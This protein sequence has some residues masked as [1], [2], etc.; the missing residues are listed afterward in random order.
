MLKILG[1]IL[2]E[3]KMSF[4]LTVVLIF[5]FCLTDLVS[6]QAPPQN[7]LTQ[8]SMED[9]MNVQ[10]YSASKK[11]ERFFNT[12]AAITVITPE[13][14]QR[15]GAT[16][17]PELLRMV[18]GLNVQQV[19]SH[20]WDI[21]ARGFNGS[22][23]SNKLL[24]LID[25]RAVYTPLYGGVFW[26]VQ[27]VVLEDIERIEVIRGPGGTLWGANAVD[28]VINIITKKARDTQGGLI[29]AGSG[30]EN[31]VQT[32]LRYGL[33]AGHKDDGSDWFYR[34]YAKYLD[35]ADGFSDTG[36][37]NDRWQMARTG[38]RA[39]NSKLTFQGDFYQ[40]FLGQQVTETNFNEP[41]SEVVDR[42]A[43]VQGGN[44]MAKYEDEDFSLQSYWDITNRNLQAFEET[45]NAFDLDFTKHFQ[46]TDR[47]EITWG[48]GYRLNLED[49]RNTSSVSITSPD[50]ADQVFNTFLQ[51]EIK[52]NDKLKLTVGS[53]LEHNIYTH[54]EVEPNVRLSYDLTDHSFLWAA[55]SRAVRTPS[56]LEEDGE[57]T[58][59]AGPTVPV[60][61]MLEGNGNLASEKMRSYELGY[62][63][64]PRENI[65]VD[66]SLYVDHYD[67]LIT[68]TTGNI[69]MENGYAVAIYPAVN[70]LQGDVE[71]FELSS[72]IKLEEWWNLKAWYAFSKSGLSAYPGIADI[73]VRNFLENS[74][75]RQNAYMRSSFD[76]P[77]AFELDCTLHYTDS[78]DHEQVPSNTELDINLTKTIRQWQISLVGQNLLRSHHYESLAGQGVTQVARSGYIKATY[79]F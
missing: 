49:D 52:I 10:V 21:S 2:G 53:K 64:E 60:F 66:L 38:F 9:L 19:N 39:E 18:P 41:F 79:K 62:R 59:A 74:F 14:I 78:F 32:T 54:F 68:Y 58:G 11:A 5:V 48:A 26:D 31:K 16:S 37:A 29:S 30:N 3:I 43:T 55:A 40:G 73:G 72:D 23:F 34:A 57:I 69:I 75:P 50:Q 8:L 22:I 44:F 76:L 36:T 70:G 7:D 56:R 51:D 27:D 17:I 1:E 4:S 47:Q 45:R 42:D 65:L 46:A 20:S 28:G 33:Q 35:E 67:D 77:Y 15:S 61:S 13:D 6:A 24:V 25:G 71:G 63:I 12:A